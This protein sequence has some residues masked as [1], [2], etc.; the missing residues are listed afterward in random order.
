MFF[1]YIIAAV[2]PYKNIL[3]ELLAIPISVILTFILSTNIV[4]TVLEKL[5]YPWKSIFNVKLCFN[6][7][8]NK[9]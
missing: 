4:V 8:I 3:T 2:L 6:K 5:I 7:F 9:Q 1:I